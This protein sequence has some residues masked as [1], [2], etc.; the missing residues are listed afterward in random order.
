MN[1][2]NTFDLSIGQGKPPL[3]IIAGP[4]AVGK[5]AAAISLAKRIGGEIVSADSM[6]V[7]RGMD[8]GTA[9]V[10]RKEMEGV[11]HHLIDVMEP[12]E[13]Y[14]VVRFQAMAKE[15]VQGILR[16]GHIPILCGGTGFYIQALLYDIDFT[17]ET[18]EEA[19]AARRTILKACYDACGRDAEQE[20]VADW[21]YQRLLL[22]DPEGAKAIPKENTK[23]VLRALSFFELH[24]EPI[25]AHNKKQQKKRENSPYAYRF[26][27]L[28]DDRTR[29]Y[30]RIDRRVD[31]MMAD[32]LFEEVQ[33]LKKRGVKK[34]ATSMQGIGYRELY[35]ALLQ[36][37]E[38][39]PEQLL[40]DAVSRIKQNSRHYAKRQLT[41]FKREGERVFWI[42]IGKTPDAAEEIFRRLLKAPGEEPPEPPIGRG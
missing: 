40:A 6:Q 22:L 4:T 27:V 13:D 15:A 14:N 21:L 31:R 25:S 26:F 7:Y 32:G 42:D 37:G 8:I 11:P 41:W 20:A 19:E 24:Q 29:L 3:I 36:S 10:T 28:T 18:K 17:E 5:S 9:K 39:P 23:R 2:Q 34:S 1:H 33:K 30:E 12:E 38:D 16:R 35:E